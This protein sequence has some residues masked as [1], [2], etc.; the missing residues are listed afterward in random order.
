MQPY[1]ALL[2]GE[3]VSKHQ[4]CCA[5]CGYLQPCFAQVSNSLSG[6]VKEVELVR[7][8]DR[9][10]YLHAAAK[11]PEDFLLHRIPVQWDSYY[12]QA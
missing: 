3:R 8:R 5:I 6:G 1:R 9:K 11:R 10:Q 7:P 12:L 2:S 4:F